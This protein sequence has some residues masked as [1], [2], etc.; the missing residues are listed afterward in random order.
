MSQVVATY[1]SIEASYTSIQAT[2]QRDALAV[3]IGGDKKPSNILNTQQQQIVDDVGI[4]Q[5]ALQKFEDAQL[6]AKQLQDYLDYLNGRV[7]ASNVQIVPANQDSSVEISGRST[8]LSASIEVATYKE[9][10]LQITADLDEDG[11]LTSLSI[12]KTT[13]SAEYISANISFE[14][15]QFYARA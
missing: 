6:I 2:S 15:T 12:D 7:D 3:K 8:K 4:S 10:T 13:I 11:N 1:R 9:E 14:D 5:E